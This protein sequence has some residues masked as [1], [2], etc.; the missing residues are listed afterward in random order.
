MFIW[1][2]C[3]LQIHNTDDYNSPSKIPGILSEM[4]YRMIFTHIILETHSVWCHMCLAEIKQHS[5][6][7]HSMNANS[8]PQPYC[9]FIYQSTNQ[10]WPTTIRLCPEKQHM[11]RNSCK[12]ISLKC[13]FLQINILHNFLHRDKSHRWQKHFF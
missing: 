8:E 12:L 11:M 10:Y 13:C 4:K 6:T 1:L 3:C 7:Q 9:T 2:V 5:I